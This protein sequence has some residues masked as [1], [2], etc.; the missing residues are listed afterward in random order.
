MNLQT[1]SENMKIGIVV[2]LL[3]AAVLIP[4]TVSDAYAKCIDGYDCRRTLGVEPLKEQI[5]QD[6]PLLDIT[7]P[8]YDHILAE[9]SNGKLACLTSDTLE[10]TWQNIDYRYIA[11]Y[12]ALLVLEKENLHYD[13]PFE[14]RGTILDGLVFENNSLIATTRPYAEQGALSLQI[15]YDLLDA[16]PKQCNFG[17]GPVKTSYFAVINDAKYEL[18]Y[19]QKFH[20]T[21]VTLMIP[22]DKH[23]KTIKIIHTCYE[24]QEEDAEISDVLEIQSKKTPITAF[25]SHENENEERMKN[26]RTYLSH[27]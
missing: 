27:M 24:S 17:I 13:V 9:R 4:L 15:Q 11:D 18:D 22:L 16:N 2:A 19:E 3:F 25:N 6:I 5:R 7:C 1:K 26:S 8:R 12:K 20:G 10:K 21:P 14:T 23:S